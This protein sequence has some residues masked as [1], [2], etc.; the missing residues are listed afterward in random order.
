MYYRI[1]SA[2]TEFDSEVLGDGGTITV[3]RKL[4]RTQLEKLTED[5]TTEL[6]IDI[7]ATVVQYHGYSEHPEYTEL[8][9]AEAVWNIVKAR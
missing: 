3:S 4:T 1:V 9:R 7:G 8:Q 6:S 2:N 5:L